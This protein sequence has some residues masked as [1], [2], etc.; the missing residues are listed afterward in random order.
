MLVFVS[1]LVLPVYA[2]TTAAG[3]HSAQ[4]VIQH[5]L[6]KKIRPDLARWAALPGRTLP[7]GEGAHCARLSRQLAGVCRSALHPPLPPAAG[8][9]SACP[10]NSASRRPAP[11]A[12]ARRCRQMAAAMQR[13][14]REGRR[15]CRHTLPAGWRRCRPRRTWRAGGRLARRRWRATRRPC[16]SCCTGSRPAT[17]LP[18]PLLAWHPRLQQAVRERATAPPRWRRRLLPAAA[19]RRSWIPRCWLRQQRRRRPAQTTRPTTASAPSLA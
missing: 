12:A 14:Q 5:A 16:P 19:P 13:R 9:C 11:R 1:L 15:S 10:C 8:P 7:A 18:H 3:S 17:S 4:S 6:K 2:L